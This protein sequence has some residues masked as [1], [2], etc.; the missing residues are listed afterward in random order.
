MPKKL[1]F[2]Q[3]MVQLEDIVR[4]L[5]QGEAT[6]EDSLKLF[7]QGTKLVSSLHGQLDA[8]Q[9]K[10]EQMMVGTDGGIQE[11]PFVVEEDSK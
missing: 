8:A 11:V 2:E 4:Q 1:T 6:L 7:E 3:S 5:E 10:V 9:Q